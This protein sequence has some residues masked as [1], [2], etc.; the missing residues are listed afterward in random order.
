MGRESSPQALKR[1]ENG[2]F[3]SR[4]WLVSVREKCE[5]LDLGTVKCDLFYA[6]ET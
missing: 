3:V 5:M 6:R 4:D 1:V 2:I